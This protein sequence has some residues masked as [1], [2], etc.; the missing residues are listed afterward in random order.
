MLS[1]HTMRQPLSQS[2]T[3]DVNQLQ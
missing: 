1:K 2:S 3:A